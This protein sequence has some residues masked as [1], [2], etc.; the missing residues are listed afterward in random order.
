MD[1]KMEVPCGWLGGYKAHFIPE[2]SEGFQEKPGTYLGTLVIVGYD[3]QVIPP[4]RRKL[5]N[6]AHAKY[7]KA[8][9]RRMGFHPFDT[10]AINQENQKALEDATREF[11]EAL[12]EYE[13]PFKTGPRYGIE[14]ETEDANS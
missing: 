3:P 4:E 8:Y 9:N 7:I 12:G 13:N 6:K 11:K 2:S 10:P 1:N 5:I 14:K